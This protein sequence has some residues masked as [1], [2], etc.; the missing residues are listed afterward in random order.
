[1]RNTNRLLKILLVAPYGDEDGNPL[2][3]KSPH[4]GLT[5]IRN[6]ILKVSTKT[7]VEL[8]DP[9]ID[10][11]QKLYEKVKTINYDI[12]SFSLLQTILKENIKIIAKCRTLTAESKFIIGGP[13]VE[14]YPHQNFFDSLL[15]DIIVLK[16]YTS[17]IEIIKQL[18]R[19]PD[20]FKFINKIPD[21]KYKNKSGDI[22]QTYSS[23]TIPPYKNNRYVIAKVNFITGK[24]I[25]HGVIGKRTLSISVGNLCKGK[26]NFCSIK[27]NT[28]FPPDLDELIFEIKKNTNN[29]DSIVLEAADIFAN[30]SYL[31]KLLDRL[32]SEKTLNYP[33]KT[34]GRV[35]EVFDE[36]LL[37]TM[38]EANIRI[39]S[40]GVESFNNQILS[41]INKQTTRQ[42]NIE[43]LE[44]TLR[45][46]I[47][48]GINLILF[49]PWDTLS[50]TLDTIT[51]TLY[52]LEKGAY[53][54]IVPG[55]RVRV[56]TPLEN[57]TDLIN[58]RNYK[59]HNMPNAV[60]V[61][62]TT[63]IIDK[64][65]Q[66]IY[67]VYEENF[68]ILYKKYRK[69]TNGSIPFYSLLVILSTLQAINDNY[70]FIPDLLKRT[71]ALVDDYI[72]TYE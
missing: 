26:C 38:Y 34:T 49:T 32:K 65:L 64:D 66:R 44:M 21:L 47:I 1:M 41:N 50:S 20:I 72:S 67:T 15:A 60:K 3:I 23:K 68:K 22:I 57:L 46:G 24:R 6:E 10:D 63:K 39:I 2:K 40:Y 11:V 13:D 28:E 30:R 35:D 69:Y 5:I 8:I 45:A 36:Q 27:I 4:L 29:I 53:T 33:I 7:Q 37:E 43:T 70:K 16:G 19:Q 62:Y 51:N 9:N 31:I 71:E 14:H 54:N 42:K 25:K 58:Y 48:P 55:L 17:F 59:Y 61:P 56:G 52:F 12:I 18:E